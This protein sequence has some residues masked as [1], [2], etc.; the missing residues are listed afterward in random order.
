MNSKN[1]LDTIPISDMPDIKLVYVMH[2]L[3]MLACVLIAF[4]SIS[5][6][7]AWL[8]PN[9]RTFLPDIWHGMKVNT[10]LSFLILSFI[11]TR[12][13]NK[14]TSHTK[15][16][17]IFLCAVILLFPLS[18]L[19]HHTFSVNFGLETMFAGDSYSNA[20]G[21]M[22]KQTATFLVGVVIV[23]LSIICDNKN[24]RY[25]QD[26]LIFVLSVI[27]LTIFSGYLFNATGLFKQSNYIYSSPHTVLCMFLVVFALFAMRI[28]SSLI[29]AIFSNGI[30]SV[31]FRIKMPLVILLH[32]FVIVTISYLINV[33]EYNVS[34][35]IALIFVSVLVIS[36]STS[37]LSTIKINMLERELVNMSLRDELT[38]LYNFRAFR[39][40][41]EH[42]CFQAQR[43]NQKIVAFF[44]DIDGLKI[45]NDNLGH[46]V[47]SELLKDF[48]D[49][50][51]ATFRTED[52][53]A[54]FGGDEFTVMI[55]YNE[56]TSMLDRLQAKIDQMNLQ[57]N[58][59]RIKYSSGYIISD[60][61][62][63]LEDI[64]SKAD[65]IMYMQKSNHNIRDVLV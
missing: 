43:N 10:A 12:D 44:F 2:M 39:L 57:H 56:S 48:A 3:K 55:Y 15:L 63:N 30:G 4:I 61:G 65:K 60:E 58:K 45:V 35:G 27:P 17:D 19:M 20:P 13:L 49:A 42:M 5:V 23:L 53:V 26:I 28:N 6:L 16:F 34:T 9:F 32:T 25:L 36:L 21:V 64:I 8:M 18:A 29:G 14:N 50:L 52:L 40:I 46:E 59:Y 1:S 24:N 11:L 22:S 31:S 7:L 54:R 33:G 47:G 51:V 37:L 38:G 41:G 62:D